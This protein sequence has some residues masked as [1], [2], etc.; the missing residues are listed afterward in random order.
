[1][2]TFQIESTNNSSNNNNNNNDN[3]N[4][5][6]NDCHNIFFKFVFSSKQMTAWN[7]QIS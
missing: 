3:N 2:L 7:L 5:N 6:N 1:M 4:N